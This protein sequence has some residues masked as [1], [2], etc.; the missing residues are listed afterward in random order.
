MEISVIIPVYNRADIVGRTLKSV[1]AQTYRP[2]HLILVDN[3]SVDGTRGVLEQFKSD[4]ED[5][6]FRI[7][8]LNEERAGASAARNAGLR[9]ADSEWVMFFDSD[10][11]M[12]PGL[13]AS[14]VEKIQSVN[15]NA[16]MVVTRGEV[17]SRNGMRRQQPYFEEDLLK[18]QIFDC[19]LNTQRY[20]ARRSLLERAGGWNESLPVWNDWEL[21]V[22]ILLLHPRVEYMGERIMVH[23]YETAVSIT[24]LDRKS[25]KGEWEKSIDS[26]YSHICD[27]DEPNKELYL[28]FVEYRRILLAGEY[29]FEGEYKHARELYETTYSRVRND[30]TMKWLYPLLYKIKSVGGVGTTRITK[31]L[32]R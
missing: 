32:V 31:L 4:S 22:R 7:T 30:K 13:I 5:K 10:D 3:N 2:I 19:C 14:Y 21:G 15:G 11:V 25:R 23:I 29:A 8:L 9:V 6:N 27:S 26:I 17:I 1:L 20:L 24:G 18:Y 28:K 12:D 16:D